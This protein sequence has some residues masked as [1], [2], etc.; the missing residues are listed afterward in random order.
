MLFE[1]CLQSVDDAIAAERGGAQ[2]VE[3]C[4]A[5]V[6]GGIT[7]SLGTI[8]A[9]RAA[10]DIDLMVMIRPRGG[11]FDYTAR[12][13]EAMAL[14]IE[15]CRQIGVTGVVFGVLNVDGTIARPQ[16]QSL[17]GQASGLSV[18]F[19]RAFDVCS[20]PASALE[21]LI[22][23]GVDR[24]LTSGQAATV[25][26][27]KGQIRQLVE[28]AA[29]RIGILP[30]CGITPENVAEL[31]DYLGVGEFHAT[32]FGT[33]HSAMR[34]QNP[35]VYMGIPGLPEYERQVTSESEVRRF[36]AAVSRAR[37]G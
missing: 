14:D 8:R 33:R 15:Q 9:C 34:H 23:L 13:L 12:E 3:L 19:H 31:V 36:L 11:D 5:L 35:A 32:A 1:V 22:G 2:R 16:V 37:R 10:I 30:G 28:Q 27:G 20:D 7:P 21:A 29:G 26:E 4:A 24:V 17:V 6:E 18:T 25:P